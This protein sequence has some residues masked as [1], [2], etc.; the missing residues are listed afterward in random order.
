[1]VIVMTGRERIDKLMVQRQLAGSRERARALIMAGRVLVDDRPVDKAGTQVDPGASIRLRGEDIPLVARIVTV[2]DG[3]DA[4]TT[5]RPYSS[6]RSLEQARQEINSGSLSRYDPEVVTA[7]NR[8]WDA[9]RIH[10]IAT[11]PPEKLS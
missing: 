9:G 3:F 10:E 2:A 1:M 7:F 11:Q 6:A 4:M 5:N 8:A